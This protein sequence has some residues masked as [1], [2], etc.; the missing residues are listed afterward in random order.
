MDKAR[1]NVANISDLTIV[2][3]GAFIINRDEVAEKNK[4]VQP[5][6]SYTHLTLPT[7]LRV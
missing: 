4:P 1:I 3:E 5:P 6:V 2:N 7:I